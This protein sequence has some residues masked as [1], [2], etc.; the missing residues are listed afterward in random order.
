MHARLAMVELAGELGGRVGEE[1]QV[2]DRA[3]D[4]GL[5]RERERL[6]GI[7]RFGAGEILDARFQRGG[8]FLQ[9]PRPFARR[10]A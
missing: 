2:A 6:A 5:L 1:T 7:A 4:L 3:R 8:Q 10:Q 9:P